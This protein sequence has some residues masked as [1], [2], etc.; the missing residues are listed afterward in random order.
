MS[1]LDKNSTIVV[2]GS[3]LSNKLSKKNKIIVFSGLALTVILISL[4]YLLIIHKTH[5]TNTKKTAVITVQAP[6]T[7]AER[8]LAEA[9]LVKAAK[10]SSSQTSQGAYASTALTSIQNQIK[11]TPIGNTAQLLSLNENAALIAA[12]LKLPIAEQYAAAA[13]K[14]FPASMPNND[15]VKN[16]MISISKGDYAAAN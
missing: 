11:S 4:G 6:K 9:E 1:N 2:V 5:K 8:A 13:L 3:N 10:A 15:T 12:Q 16:K 14:L 7:A